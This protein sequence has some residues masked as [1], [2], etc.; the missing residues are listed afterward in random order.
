MSI[1]AEI[2]RRLDAQIIKPEEFPAYSQRRHSF[3]EGVLLYQTHR[4]F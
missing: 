4:L 2:T 3:K 1:S